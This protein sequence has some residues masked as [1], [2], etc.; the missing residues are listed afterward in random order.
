M[1]RG[2]LEQVNRQLDHQLNTPA[3]QE[4]GG[5][6]DQAFGMIGSA[7]FGKAF[8]L[9]A[10]PDAVRERYGR[11]KLGQ[12]TLL[13]RRLV[14]QGVPLVTVYWNGNEQQDWDT[15]Y[16]ETRHLK[17]LLPPTDR[18][19]SALLDDLAARGLLDETLVVWMGEFGRAPRIE[20]KGGRGHWARCYSVVMA[21]GGIQGG[22]V[23]GRSDRQAGYPAENAVSPAD[24]VT[25]IYHCLG[26]DSETE[27][28]DH[29]GRPL[30]LCLG[31][32]IPPLLA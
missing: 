4:M 20:E 31:T 8:D 11:N 22:Q 27:I 2:L 30:K 1:R 6:Y 7:R 13:A 15:H 14:E 17:N 5:H 21:G 10:E 12:G 24:I 19:F 29:L 32:V 18:A 25:T 3:F 28:T 9:K 16:E 23:Y 26:I